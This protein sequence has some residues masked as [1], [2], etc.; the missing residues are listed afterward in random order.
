[1][2]SWSGK[3][4]SAA[5]V[6]QSSVAE[7]GL[8]CVTMIARHHGKNV[9]LTDLRQKF[10]ISSKGATLLNL[11]QI[12][13]ELK[14][15]CRPVKCELDDLEHLKMPCVLHWDLDH[16]VVLYKQKGSKF[17]ILDPGAGKRVLA[18]DE[19]SKHFTGVALEL[20][21]TADFE[22]QKKPTHK[23]K[24][25]DLF[26]FDKSYIKPV[27]QALVLTLVVQAFLLAAP[28]FVQF[29]IDEGI[30]NRDISLIVAIAVGFLLIKVFEIASITMRQLIFQTL[31]KTMIFEL[32]SSL[33]HHLIRLPVP[34]IHS[35]SVG[36]VQT[37]FEE[38]E[39]I[40]Q[41]LSD[42]IIE[43]IID[44]FFAII[45]GAVLFLYNWVLALIVCAC[46]VLYAA[47]KVGAF[48]MAYRLN[49]EI[50]EKAALES[51]HF[52][53]TL[54]AFQTLKLSGL[55]SQRE[56]TWRNR[57]LEVIH[58]NIRSG[59][60]NIGFEALNL[61][62][63][64]LSRIVIVMLAAM[65]V[66]QGNL[67]VGMLTAFL[68]YQGDFERRLTGLVDKAITLSLLRVHVD[69]LS[70]I[71]L[72]EPERET[73]DAA[74]RSRRLEGGIEFKSVYFRY[75]PMEEDVLS[76]VNF[77][78]EPGEFVA[79][80][81]PSGQGKSTILKLMCSLYQP[82][83]GEIL[84]D[85]VALTQ[86]GLANLRSQI[87]IVMQDDRILDGTLGDNITLF[88]PEIDHERMVHAATLAC[89]HD[90]IEE[91]PM[92]Y[93]T[94]GGDLGNTLSG[95]QQQRVMIARA[96]YRNPKLLILDEG[97][98]QLDVG[99]EERI[100]SNLRALNITRFC[101]AHRPDTLRKADRVLMV[102]AGTVEPFE[103]APRALPIVNK[104]APVDQ[105]PSSDEVMAV[106]G[107][108][109]ERLQSR[110][111]K[112]PLGPERAS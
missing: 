81:G 73:A 19:I 40:A 50:Q 80:A 108:M 86:F 1:M 63:F 87:G 95:G 2:I 52:L 66:V 51:S 84:F 83:Q 59:N 8:A 100:N 22:K 76:D 42:D 35:R 34:Y 5:L 91:M 46:A 97:T 68:A 30:I 29:V 67:T 58:A 79:L 7:C 23:L 106:G 4:S 93:H 28:L 72:T 37:R 6:M 44:G 94:L 82:T 56:L 26:T 92:G 69:R 27:S 55:E 13:Q 77:T 10:G 105:T 47:L 38:T 65:A 49:R 16:F 112:T 71:V 70:E 36:D 18:I 107:S 21:P 9:Q 24:L 75:A 64:G 109:F 33:F 98:S 54:S 90:E 48:Q 104:P 53:N 15:A 110:R 61:S 11:V 96:L 17:E 57:H 62:V 41:T 102:N 32:K 85:G 78:I 74:G 25:V 12:A 60:L 89:I 103:G 101:A 14:F 111:R 20:D 31:S 99:L 43:A 3:S 88:D 39:R 45:I